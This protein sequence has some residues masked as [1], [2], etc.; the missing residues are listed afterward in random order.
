VKTPETPRKW[1][2]V[3]EDVRAVIDGPMF[4]KAMRLT[5][6][7]SDQDILDLITTALEGGSNY[8]YANA[9][10]RWKAGIGVAASVCDLDESVS[11]TDS[12]G[13]PFYAS[14][15]VYRGLV[16]KDNCILVDVPDLK[17][18]SRWVFPVTIDIVRRGLARTLIL[19]P[20]QYAAHTQGQGD[21]STAD[22]VLQFAIFGDTVFA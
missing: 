1:S 21:A 6:G 19:C 13:L 16:E 20:H 3:P 5:Q 12:T 18:E 22:V 17:D 15:S 7:W 2:D 4:A 9:R 14:H 8:W 10:A 11:R